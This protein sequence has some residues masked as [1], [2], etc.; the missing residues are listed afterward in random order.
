MYMII[1]Q[2]EGYID[3]SVQD[4]SISIAYALEIL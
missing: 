2:Y 1:Y 3:G 4:Y